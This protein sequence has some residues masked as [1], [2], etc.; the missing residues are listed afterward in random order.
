LPALAC[1]FVWYLCV[2]ATLAAV[3]G[4]VM[5]RVRQ[6][7]S[8][9]DGRLGWLFWGLVLVLAGRHL[10]APVENQSHDLLG[11]LWVLLAM[12]TW[13]RSAGGRTDPTAGAWAGVATA[14]KATPLLLLPLFVWQRRWRAVAAMALTCVVLTLATD[15]L[16]PRQDGG[17]LVVAWF[18]TFLSRAT[19]G[20]LATTPTWDPWCPLNQSLSG[21][22]QRLLTPLPAE[23][24]AEHGWVDVSVLALSPA[25]LRVVTLA[26]LAAG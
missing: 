3:L 2:C 1:R 23:Q 24:A 11:F 8:A 25:A 6:A 18:Q 9:S 26:G 12:D 16:W 15:V 21:T 19:P 4:L 14:L 13:S 17:L 10:L 22:L 20:D 5:R 7:A